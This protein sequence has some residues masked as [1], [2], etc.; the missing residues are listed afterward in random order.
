MFLI[1]ILFG[2]YVIPRLNI[3]SDFTSFFFFEVEL[4]LLSIKFVHS[5]SQNELKNKTWII[6]WKTSD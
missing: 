3:Y 5:Q 2:F 4:I 6:R 1:G